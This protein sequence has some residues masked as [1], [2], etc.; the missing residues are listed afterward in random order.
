MIEKFKQY[1]AALIVETLPSYK[2]IDSVS[3]TFQMSQEG[4][5]KV[6]V[7]FF[8]NSLK[9]KNLTIYSFFDDLQTQEYFNLMLSLVK[10]ENVTLEQVGN[11]GTDFLN[12]FF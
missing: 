8:D 10:D 7:W 3:V 5:Y 11:C 2:K 9:T 6:E 12:K 1:A 4:Y